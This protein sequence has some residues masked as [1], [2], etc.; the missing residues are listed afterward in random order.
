MRGDDI[1]AGVDTSGEVHADVDLDN[2]FTVSRYP[3]SV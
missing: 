2:C 3:P 1:H